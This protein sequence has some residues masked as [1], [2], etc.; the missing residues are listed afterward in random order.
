MLLLRPLRI[1]A[2][3][4]ALVAAAGAYG[5]VV[6]GA[7]PTS[8]GSAVLAARGLCQVLAA[9]HVDPAAILGLLWL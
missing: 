6:G 3:V 1:A 7:S 4:V 8:P 5:A 9:A 2:L